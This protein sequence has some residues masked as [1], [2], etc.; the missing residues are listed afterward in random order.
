[1]WESIKAF[2]RRHRRKFFITGAVI[3]GV[4]LVGR[5]ARWRLAEWQREQEM[6]YVEQARKQHHFESNLRTCTVTFFS[7][8]PSLREALMEKLNCESITAR[9]REKPANK[10]ELWE[11][12][13]ILSFTR[14]LTSVYSSCMLFVFL[15]VQLNI[16]GGYLYLDSLM[17]TR[18]NS[19]GTQVHIAESLQ[20]RYLALVRYLLGDGLDFLVGEI[21]RSVEDIL[22]EASLKERF[23]HAQLTRLVNHIRQA[24]EHSNYS[25]PIKKSTLGAS[26]G[27]VRNGHNRKVLQKFMIPQNIESYC[28][29]SDEEEDDNFR[30]LVGETLDILDSHD[31]QTVLKMCLDSGFSNIMS[32]MIPFFQ[33]GDLDLGAVGGDQREPSLDLPLAKIIP[34]VNGQVNH[35]L[36]DS[37]N[38]YFQDLFKVGCARDFAANVYE[39][40]S[41]EVD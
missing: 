36:C 18:E 17:L 19:S 20:K 15:R 11:E 5:Y 23:S 34:V 28:G 35:I 9:L 40:F 8:V 1:M 39:A 26:D 16:V 41:V 37:D 10:L 38:S 12:L 27:T 6:E 24:I 21:R 31:C 13:K 30:N 3:G 7:L 4:Y 2:L 25:I 33:S 32:N 14:T 29:S 22:G